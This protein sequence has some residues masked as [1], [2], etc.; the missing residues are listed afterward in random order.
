VGRRSWDVKGKT[1]GIKR[2]K[3]MVEFIVFLGV[4]VGLVVVGYRMRVDKEKEN[5]SLGDQKEA[6]FEYEDDSLSPEK[7]AENI[8]TNPLYDDSP[9]NVFYEPK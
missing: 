7:Q 5:G 3:R 9:G 8:V 1:H 2:G 4:I 6:Y